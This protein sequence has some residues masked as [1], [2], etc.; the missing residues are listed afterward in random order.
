MN[1]DYRRIYEDH[2]SFNN[3]GGILMTDLFYIGLSVV[4]LLLS[5][6][7]ITF[8]DHLMENRK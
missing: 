8:C 1:G 5:W 3:L 7:F 4:L 2:N 6:G